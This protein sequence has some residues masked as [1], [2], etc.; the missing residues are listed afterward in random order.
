MLRGAW[1]EKEQEWKRTYC[2]CAIRKRVACD[3]CI[4][5]SG[6][7][8]SKAIRAISIDRARK[9]RRVNENTS[10]RASLTQVFCLNVTNV[11]ECRWW[12]IYI[13]IYII[14]ASTNSI[15]FHVICFFF[16]L[17]YFLTFY[18]IKIYQ[19]RTQSIQLPQP[20]CHLSFFFFLFF[21]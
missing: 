20:L 11:Q 10:S 7:L 13:Y 14:T 5:A 6:T 17:K 8:P 19:F 12:L 16:F 15:I 18:Y 4:V 1:K 21:S 2:P 9:T 3:I